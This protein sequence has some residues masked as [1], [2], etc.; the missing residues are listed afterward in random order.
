MQIVPTRLRTSSS[1]LRQRG[2]DSADLF[3]NSPCRIARVLRAGDGAADDEVVG[4]AAD[5]ISWGHDSP[6]VARVCA[7]GP[8]A[9]RHDDEI[10]PACLPNHFNLVW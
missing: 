10:R 1:T 4:A 6:L 3:S 2:S 9:R 7:R 8:N 5:R